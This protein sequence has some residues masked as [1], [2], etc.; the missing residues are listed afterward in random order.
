MAIARL[1][2]VIPAYNEEARL[3]GTLDAIARYARSSLERAELLVVD[4]G[5]SDRTAQ[6]ARMWEARSDAHVSVRALGHWPNQG[7]GASVRQGTLA[8]SEPY[9]LMSDADLSTPI[10]D[11]EKLARAL[12]DADVA[13]GSR[14][15]S[16]SVVTGRQPLYRQSM[17]KIFNRFVR[18]VAVHGISDTQCGFKLFKREVAQAVFSR[19]K[20]TRFAFDVEA[21]YVA[22]RLGYQVVEIPVRWHN[23]PASK[24]H[25]IVDSARMLW[26]LFHIRSQ[27][28]D[29]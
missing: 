15:V 16:G 9:I 29:L 26:D 21:I 1:S 6:I 20:L 5:S 19:C 14:S 11:L 27:H 17:G 8:A 2:V 24:V 10:E 4:D 18:V 22:R 7:K 13:I 12:E 25:P 23:S 3:Q 28:P